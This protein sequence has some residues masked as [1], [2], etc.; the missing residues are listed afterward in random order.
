MPILKPNTPAKTIAPQKASEEN[1][2]PLND[3]K[4]TLNSKKYMRGRNNTHALQLL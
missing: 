2:P 1:V 3:S 4:R